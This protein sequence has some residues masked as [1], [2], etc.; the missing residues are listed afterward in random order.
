MVIAFQVSQQSI[1]AKRKETGS[2]ILLYA[3]ENNRVVE[4][5]ERKLAPYKVARCV[6]FSTVEKRLRKPGHGMQVALMIVRNGEEMD[7]IHAIHN[8]V[9][10]VKLIL[11]LPTHDKT[12]VARAHKLGPRFIAYADN[13]Y[14]Q[15][16]AVLEKMLQTR[17][18]A[19]SS[20]RYSTSKIE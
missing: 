6:S 9:R 14:D 11:V 15:V 17:P 10:D 5:L 20:V 3:A 12:M 4:T 16:G 19:P 13:G 8:L 1:F 2:V 7:L 18:S